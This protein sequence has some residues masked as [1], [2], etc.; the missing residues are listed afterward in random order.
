[1]VAPSSADPVSERAG[2]T[3]ENLL[4]EVSDFTLNGGLER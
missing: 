1:M 2:V 3:A 4:K